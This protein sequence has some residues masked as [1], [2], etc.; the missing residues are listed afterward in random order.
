[1]K[2]LALIA[3]AL[4]SFG[5]GYIS[6]FVASNQIS[7][8]A[9]GRQPYADATLSQPSGCWATDSRQFDQNRNPIL[10]ASYHR[11]GIDPDPQNPTNATM[12]QVQYGAIHYNS[13]DSASAGD[14]RQMLYG[15]LHN[16][17][18]GA[19]YGWHVNVTIQHDHLAKVVNGPGV[20][21]VRTWYWAVSQGTVDA[22]LEIL[23]TNGRPFNPQQLVTGRD[24]QSAQR[25]NPQTGED[26]VNGVQYTFNQSLPVSA[27][28]HRARF[29]LLISSSVELVARRPE[30]SVG[31]SS[32]VTL[33]PGGW[34]R[35]IDNGVSPPAILQKADGTNAHWDLE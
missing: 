32:R 28:D 21:N 23:D 30:V 33:K 20:P 31:G 25:S 7:A 16:V 13:Q 29:L 5:V 8:Q 11:D 15:T 26:W 22:S 27:G 34:I 6:G 19:N 10:D 1:M 4:A 14:R 3:L 35:A 18:P 2:S 17:P 9:G 24:N 12:T